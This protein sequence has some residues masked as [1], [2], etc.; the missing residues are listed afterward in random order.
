[1]ATRIGIASLLGMSIP[2]QALADH[3]HHH[4]AM[5]PNA[6]PG[7]TISASV[8]LTAAQYSTV[9]FVGDYQGITP[10]LRWA[11]GRFGASTSIGLY[12]LTRNGAVYRG[13]GDLVVQGQAAVLARG[14]TSAGVVA[15]VSAPTGSERDG[16]GMGHVMVMPGVWGSWSNED[17]TLAVSGGYGRAIGASDSGGHVH[18]TGPIVDPMNISEVTWGASGEV[19]LAH[20]LRVGARVAGAVALN[21]SGTDR[22]IGAV[23]AVWKEGRVETVAE[24]QLGLAGD[25][26]NVRGIVETA[27]RF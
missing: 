1:M 21:A 4:E 20:A 26:F 15:A 25:P 9:S 16:L 5:A 19:G 23:R 18:G 24:L 17:V 14:A 2:S 3:S 13:L 6:D 12:R 27:L 22:T 7:S 10:S 8:A 11:E